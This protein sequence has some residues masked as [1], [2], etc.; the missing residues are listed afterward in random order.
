MGKQNMEHTKTSKPRLSLGK[1]IEM[2]VESKSSDQTL[3]ESY[4]RDLRIVSKS[5]LEYLKRIKKYNGRPS[6]FRKSDAHFYLDGFTSS[7]TYY[8]NIKRNISALFQFGVDREWL[9]YNPF[10]QI[11]FKAVEYVKHVPFQFDQMIELLKFI[12]KTGRF[13]ELR[14]CANLVYS[15]FL[16]PHQEIR[17]LK[18]CDFSPDLKQIILD[19]KRTKNSRRRVVAVDEET[20]SML[21]ERGLLDLEDHENIWSKKKEPFGQYYFNN[22]WR[23]MAKLDEEY[24]SDS[25]RD[26]VQ[27]LKHGQTLYSFRHTGAI[28]FYKIHQD[29]GA[30]QRLL[31]HSNVFTTETYLRD[32]ALLSDQTMQ[33]PDKYEM[34]K[35]SQRKR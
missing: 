11:K 28:A 7:K 25:S 23:W 33:A 30:L 29:I 6:C 22:Q 4:L 14:I 3:S 31:D 20:R 27:I 12:D 15:S 26:H 5:F 13:Q 16:R 35:F 18:K 10:K 17:L 9:E 19:G 1:T 32:L 21:I 8:N 34:L 24:S 2:I